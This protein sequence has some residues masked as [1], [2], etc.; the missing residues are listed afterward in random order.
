M[1]EFTT[2]KVGYRAGVYGC[3]AEYF[4]TIIIDGDKHYSIRFHGLYGAEERVAGALK[5][6]GYKEFYTASSFGRMVQSDVR[7][8]MSEHVAIAEIKSD[9]F[10][11]KFY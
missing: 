6:L 11:A 2:I 7:G 4:T 1:K 10:K 3:I 8:S 5:A 9:E